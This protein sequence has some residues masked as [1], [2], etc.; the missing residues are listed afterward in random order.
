MKTLESIGIEQLMQNLPARYLPHERDMVLKAY[1]VAAEAHKDQKRASGEP[2]VNHCIAVANILSEMRM[3][4]EVVAAGLLH[5]TVE[6]TSLSLKDIEDLFSKT[7]AD[8]VNGVTKLD[9]LPR[10]SRSDS[11]ETAH[12]PENLTNLTPDQLSKRKKM[13]ADET[14]RKTFLAMNDDVRVVIIK[15]ADRLHNMRTLGYTKPEKQK[16][17]AQETLDIYS[18]IASRLGI[19]QIK[20]EM[21]D[22]AFRYVYPEKYKEIA[23][24]LS[25]R[26]S[27]REDQVK[28]IIQNVKAILKQ[29]G[30]EA[31]VSGRPKHIYSIWVKMQKKRKTFDEVRDVRGIRLLVQ[32]VPLCYAALGIVHNKW[33]PIPGEFDDYIAAPKENFYQS[34]HTAVIYED[35]QPLE[36]QIRT[37]EMHQSA[38]YGIAAH[39]RYKDGSK[40]DSKYEEQI[41]SLRAMLKIKDEAQTA[42]EFVESMK[43][44]VFAD[45][46]YVFTPKGDIID[47]PSGST[48]IDFAYHVHT[49]IGHRCR[50][51]KINDKLVTLDTQLKTGDR[52]V[53][54]TSKQGGPSR[55]W[56]NPS[57]GLVKTQRAL[58]K[59]RIWF[60]KQDHDQNL[61][62]GRQ[63]LE[64]EFQRLG[65]S[66]LNL[67]NLARQLECR[68]PEDMFVNLGC[69][70]L[71]ISRVVTLIS[72]QTPPED[73]I[74]TS[75]P[76]SET[77]SSN[78]V[79][80]RGLGGM[81]T[82]MA[83]CCNPTLGDP[84]IGYIT[85]GRGATI[86]RQDCPNILKISTTSEKDRLAK[87]NWG[88]GGKTYPV[89]IRINAIDRQG[90]MG[91]I[92]NLLDSEG[93]NITNVNVQVKHGNL[94]ADMASI[95][96]VV[97]VND[98]QQLSRVLNRLE[99]VTNIIDAQ[100]IKAG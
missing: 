48:P 23:E 20:W 53:I 76:K 1:N 63:M 29:A 5:D 80:V 78:A 86:H 77:T 49:D 34:L 15:L 22:L 97:E 56:L 27:A 36:V 19:W 31:E 54:I 79:T 7:I 69:G 55:D 6:D 85:R 30:I 68:N 91:D 74:E 71:S 50:G 89:P 42:Q 96:L 11:R 51:A 62:Q 47:L 93:V 21:E 3:P 46:V 61:S 64:R 4:G 38:E 70:D 58:A 95:R 28:N 32:D 12:E 52:V 25:N 9:S 8:L 37:H 98:I 81:L 65:I 35:G 43:S 44:D 73:V 59:I 75:A 45:R 24:Q 66:E 26:R 92:S 18:H 83:R 33:R 72:E 40:R 57:L 99:N 10:V 41:Q 84:I 88:E 13:L 17:I 82:Q 14:L 2:Y 90:L 100:R 39:W 94:K 60:K 67:E 87:V 16:R